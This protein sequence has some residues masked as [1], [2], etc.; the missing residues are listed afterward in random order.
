[1]K[2]IHSR[3]QKVNNCYDKKETPSYKLYQVPS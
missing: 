2:T 1:M 3:F